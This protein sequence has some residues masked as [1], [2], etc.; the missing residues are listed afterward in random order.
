MEKKCGKFP[1]ITQEQTAFFINYIWPS[2]T[3]K[4]HKKVNL[5]LQGGWLPP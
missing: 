4:S 5:T 1:D 2:G 3:R